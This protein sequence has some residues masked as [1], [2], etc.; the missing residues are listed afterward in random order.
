MR[1]TRLEASN[2]KRLVAVDVTPTGR[3]TVVGGK[4]RQGKSSVLDAIVYALAGKRQIP[5]KPL[6]EGETEGKV[7]L[8]LDGDESRGLPPMIVER[9]FD[10]DGTTRL[11]IR[12]DNSFG[13]QAPSPQAILDGLWSRSGFD[14]LHFLRLKP[15]EQVDAIRKIIPG[16]DF[17]ELDK[18]RKAIY[19]QRTTVNTESKALHTRAEG[20]T[21]S[22][23][24]PESEIS[25]R[26]L[27][28]ELRRRN[29]ANQAKEALAQRK[30][31]LMR[32]VDGLTKESNAIRLQI[33]E[34][35]DTQAKKEAQAISLMDQVEAASKE[36]A[37]MP[38]FDTDEIVVQME[39]AEELNELRRTALRKAELLAAAKTLDDQSKQ[40]TD[41]IAA[42]DKRKADAISSA[43]LPVPGLGFSADGLMLNGLPFEQ[44]SSAEQLEVAV[45]M[46]LS[47][48]PPLRVVLVHDG[49]LMDDETLARMAEVAERYD[50][51]VWIERVSEGPECT[52]VIEEGVVKKL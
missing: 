19:D 45:A 15:R 4:N 38:T 36:A 41:D 37:V 8:H 21:I 26:E 23:D 24:T 6:R 34:L 43:E 48:N 47:G 44:A 32:Q 18:D 29:A 9:F 12:E 28:E 50:A 13:A 5:D 10:E 17:E 52:V 1:I 51:Q 22:P 11:E 20:I 40:L 33:E 39:K 2:I 31:E 7:T 30:S 49:S 3:L 25:V 16:L 27:A 42:I 14:P 35:R 46:A